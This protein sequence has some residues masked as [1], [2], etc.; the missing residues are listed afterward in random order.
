M[1]PKE[2]KKLARGL[3][4]PL[5]L[6][7]VKV[8]RVVLGSELTGATVVGKTILPNKYYK[9][10]ETK[11]RKVNV[12]DS[13][14]KFCKQHPYHNPIDLLDTYINSYRKNHNSMVGKYP[15]LFKP[16]DSE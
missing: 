10:V 16:T 2:I 6:E 12:E 13:F 15:K 11:I 9:V 4:L 5:S 8:N 7:E 14:V 1:K 3:N